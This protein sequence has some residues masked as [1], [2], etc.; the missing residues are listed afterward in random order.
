M[1]NTNPLRS[2]GVVALLAMIIVASGGCQSTPQQTMVSAIPTADST[3]QIQAMLDRAARDP[4][5]QAAVLYLQASLAY[6]DLANYSQATQTFALIEPGW[7]PRE[8]L[9]SYQL[10]NARIAIFDNDLI[11]AHSALDAVA[12]ADPLANS[13]E[14]PGAFARRFREVSAYLCAAEGDYIC[15]ANRLM[16]ANVAPPYQHNDLIWSY[17]GRASGY[18]AI[19]L[20][21]AA[22]GA[23]GAGWWQLKAD[24]LQSQSTREQRLTLKAWRA[25]WPEHPANLRLPLAVKPIETADWQPRHIGLMLPLS[26]GLSRAGRAIRDGFIAAYLAAAASSAARPDETLDP[27]ARAG[28]VVRVSFYDTRSAPL[29]LLYERILADGVDFLIGPLQKELVTQLNSLNPEI[30]TLALNY[31][32]RDPPA[33]NLLQLGLIIEDEAHTIGQRMQADGIENL[34]L[35]HTYDEWSLRAKRALESQWLGQITIQSFTDVKTITEAVGVAMKVS[36]SQVRHQALSDAFSFDLEFLP[37]AR[38]DLHGIVALVDNVEAN[39]LVPA[40]RFHF[41]QDLPVYA[42]SQSIRGARASEL[43]E[44]E[45]FRVSELPWHLFDD[46]LYRLI[47]E[48]FGL[49]ENPYSQLFAL[50]VDALRVS[51]RISSLDRSGTSQMLGSTGVLALLPNGKF[52]RELTWGVVRQSMLRARAF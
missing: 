17:M 2:A 46:P 29:P 7:L 44:L 6:T 37:R 50:G 42:S 16:S 22:V 34:L 33:A 47:D 3:V 13:R 23:V 12:A 26:G 19:R 31:L 1:L 51:E 36:T 40:L 32:D 43:T 27:S 45:G 14:F 11:T 38:H 52:R 41:A 10:L 5:D 8:Q 24:L 30:P 20:A 25:A 21:T 39:A 35:L 15:A 9:P 48:T 28:E 18:A 4:A 49:T